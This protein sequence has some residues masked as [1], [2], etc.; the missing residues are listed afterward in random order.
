MA[1]A[2]GRLLGSAFSAATASSQAEAF[3]EV[4]YTLEQPA[5]R[6]LGLSGT[7]WVVWKQGE[8]D[9]PARGV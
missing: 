3:R 7:T 9:L 6:R 2:P 1:V 5:W 8:S 4:M